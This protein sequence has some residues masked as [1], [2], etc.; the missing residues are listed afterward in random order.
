MDRPLPAQQPRKTYYTP[1]DFLKMLSEIRE[2]LFPCFDNPDSE[3]SKPATGVS[4]VAE[5]LDRTAGGS[6]LYPHKGR[7]VCR[8]CE[9]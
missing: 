3:P 1:D 8:N 9:R 5:K 7:I 2:S 6:A 4:E